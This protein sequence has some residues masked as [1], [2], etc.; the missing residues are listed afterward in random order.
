MRHHDRGVRP[1][2]RLAL[3]ITL[4]VA[5]AAGLAQAAAAAPIP[6]RAGS[7]PVCDAVWTDAARSRDVPL[8]IRM[9]TGTGP[10]P[11]V[12][13]SHGLGGS[14]DAGTRWARAWAEAGVAV[15]HLQHPGSDEGLWRGDPEAG[16]RARLLEDLRKGMTVQTFLDRVADVR[17]ALDELER[18][19]GTR[20]GACD[21]SRLDLGRVG[22]AG[23]SYGAITTQ[24][25]A[26][27]GLPRGYSARDPRIRAAVAFSPSPGLTLD[28]ATSFGAMS[29]PFLSVTGGRDVVPGLS[30]LAARDRRR[31]FD[32]MPR[33]DKYLLWFAGADHMILSGSD[34]GRR[35]PDPADAAIVAM[36]SRITTLFWRALL[37]DDAQA[38]AE[39]ERA[40]REQAPGD[41][42][43]S[44]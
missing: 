10:V 17:F 6:D 7:G 23:H 3:I 15:I 39:L 34:E 35:A 42:L 24:A 13:F 4:V 26:G 22:M 5:P 28:D 31:P 18:R 25:V 1:L 36:A 33:G 9:P 14:R 19:H 38:R 8:R 2:V 11:V 30:D 43:E 32:A 27:Q 37:M 21:L 29:L 12:L 16:D 20:E 40:G 41:A 44:K